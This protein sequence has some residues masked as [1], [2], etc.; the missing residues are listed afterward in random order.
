MELPINKIIQGDCLEVMKSFPDKSVD[1]VLT[2]PPYGLGRKLHDGGT[3]AINPI[4]DAMIEW[5]D[6]PMEQEYINEIFR[7]SKNQIIWGGHLYTLPISR[8]WLS[9]IKR[10]S[11]PTLGDFEL[12][13]TSFDKVSKCWNER[14]N[15]D[16]K[17]E[18]PTQKPISLM[19]WCIDSYTTETDLILDCFAG[20][21]SILVAAKQ[22]GRKYIGI[23]I[24]EK[25]CKIAEDR[26]RQEVLF[27]T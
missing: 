26:L 14:R 22:L 17:R 11:M 19:K 16:G 20:S 8:C 18:H 2:D 12:A 7:I 3:W 24:S 5:D 21:G 27:F 23:E 25:Y 4:Y 13:W 10:E 9:W 15:P 6:H 1:L